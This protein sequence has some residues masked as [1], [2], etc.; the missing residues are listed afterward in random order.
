MY[1]K[2][3]KL[4]IFLTT[5]AILEFVGASAIS[6]KSGNQQFN[7][8]LE[9]RSISPSEPV[10]LPGDCND[11]SYGCSSPSICSAYCSKCKYC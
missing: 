10:T 4:Y 5:I 11:M 7:S 6:A 8:R 9:A 1:S 3:F 2:V